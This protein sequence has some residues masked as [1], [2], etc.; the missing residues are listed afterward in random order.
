[1]NCRL[2]CFKLKLK[3]HIF[4]HFEP[5]TP[6]SNKAFLLVI[7]ILNGNFRTVEIIYNKPKGALTGTR[8]LPFVAP[9]K[10][11]LQEQ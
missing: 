5:Y 3:T 7:D 6:T 2:G 9:W 4:K 11:L 8:R 1:M 10:Y